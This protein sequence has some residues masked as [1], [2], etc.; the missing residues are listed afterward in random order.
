[1][2]KPAGLLNGSGNSDVAS[3]LMMA[4]GVVAAVASA[5][6]GACCFVLGVSP[7][8]ATTLIV[9]YLRRPLN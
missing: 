6:V 1:M 2:A 7:I 5:C 4:G 8:I 9:G 3:S